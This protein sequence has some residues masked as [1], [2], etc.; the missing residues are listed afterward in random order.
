[1]AR[2]EV[3]Y[4]YRSLKTHRNTPKI[5]WKTHPKSNTS[6]NLKPPEFFWLPKYE[7]FWWRMHWL[8]KLMIPLNLNPERTSLKGGP[9]RYYLKYRIDCR[10][11]L[12][13]VKYDHRVNCTLYKYNS[14]TI[15][16][17]WVFKNYRQNRWFLLVSC[18]SYKCIRSCRSCSL[19]SNGL[20]R[21]LYR[22]TSGSD[23][24]RM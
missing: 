16:L 17:R 24:R 19:L 21:I 6:R 14:I 15:L 18:I 13:K 22:P 9:K 4:C 20:L 5:K 23:E 10:G 3:C 8:W 7:W 11:I 12:L 2:G 1:M